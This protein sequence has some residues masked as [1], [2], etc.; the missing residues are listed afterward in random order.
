VRKRSINYYCDRR[1]L[2]VLNRKLEGNILVSQTVV[3][4]SE[5]IQ[6]SLNVDLILGVKIDL[7]GLG[8]VDLVADSLADD[9]SW[10]NDIL[11][12]LLVD[13]GQCA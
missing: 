4:A 5:G 3:N 10:V 6:L 11:K 12:D 9:F 7:K 2:W 13:V 1:Y 8:T